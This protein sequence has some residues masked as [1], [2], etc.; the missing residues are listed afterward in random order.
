MGTRFKSIAREIW[1]RNGITADEAQFHRRG[2]GLDSFRDPGLIQDLNPAA[3]RVSAAIDSKERVA[4]YGDYDCDGISSVA[5]LVRFLRAHGLEPRP[6]LASRE[7]GYGLTRINRILS[8]NPDL[9]IVCDCGTSDEAAVIA[10]VQAGC[11]VIVIDHHTVPRDPATHPATHLLNPKRGDSAHPFTGLC[12]AALSWVLCWIVSRIRDDGPPLEL[13][14]VAALGQVADAGTMR[15]EGRLLTR[16]GLRTWQRSGDPHLDT[17]TRT[18]SNRLERTV[19]TLGWTIGPMIN[20]AG[21]LDR[22]EIALQYLLATGDRERQFLAERLASLNTERRTL[23]EA[24]LNQARD[25]LPSGDDAILVAGDW[26]SGVSGLIASR[27]ADECDK[28]VLALSTQSWTGSARGRDGRPVYPVLQAVA[29]ALTTWGGHAVAAG[30]ATTEE[31]LPT[32]RDAVSNYRFATTGDPTAPEPIP[33]AVG[34]VTTALIQMIEGLG[35]YGVG[36]SKPE[37]KIHAVVKRVIRMGAARTHIKLV[38][39]GTELQAVMWNGASRCDDLKLE[40]NQRVEIT[41]SL[42]LNR[43]KVVRPQIVVSEIESLD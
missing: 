42:E 23:T 34:D 29:P 38:L 11:D 24:G 5:V 35:P 22:P 43:W 21:R 27:L 40:S 12:S 6:F 39:K 17:L 8:G 4:I 2:V 1:R 16:L 7:A 15:L 13:T 10:L 31:L 25:R 19:T 41:G 33:I 37:F 30:F 3:Q 26:C 14:P 20:A 28:P 36:F 32:L 9:V 18:V